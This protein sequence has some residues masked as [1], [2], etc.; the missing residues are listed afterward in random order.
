M[1]SDL[2]TYNSM[3]KRC[4]SVHLFCLLFLLLSM[5]LCA[6]AQSDILSRQ[7]SLPS[8]YSGSTDSLLSII[9]SQ[10]DITISYS[11]KVYANQRVSIVPSTITLGDLLDRIF[12]RFPVEY[13][14]REGRLSKVIVA[15]KKVRRFTLSGYCRDARTGELLIGANV[16]DTLL[17]AG[18]ATNDYGFF[19][20]TLPEGQVGAKASFVGYRTKRFSVNLR[21]DTL[22]YI[23]LEPSLYLGNVDVVATERT[24][25]DYG[26]GTV[27][28]PMEQVKSMPS[29]MGEAD[30]IKALQSTPGVQSG[31]EGFG[32]MSVRGGN[33]DQNIIM[34]DDV[35]LYGP[36]HL[37]GLYSIFN[38]ESVNSAT[39][40]KGGFPARYGGRLSSVLDVKMK[41]GNMKQYNGYANIGLLAS[42]AT[43]EG[44]IVKDKMSFIVSA[45]RTYADIFSTFL[46]RHRDQRYSFFFYDIHAKVNYV[47][48][49]R[50]RVYAS[51]FTGYDNFD[52]GY[53]YREVYSS[54]N[55][56]HV[57]E[58]NDK[59]TVRWGNIVASARWNHLFGSSLFS[60]MTLA[61]S[62]YRFSNTLDNYASEGRLKFTQGYYSG[63]NDY[64]AQA[65]FNWYTPFRGTNDRPGSNVVR[66]GSGVTYHCF[67]PGMFI[68]S[69]SNDSIYSGMTKINAN[70]RRR[71]YRFENHSYVESD[72][73]L[74]RLNVNAGLHLSS[75]MCEGQSTSVRVE[76]RLL[77]GYQINDRMR[78]NMGFSDMTQFMQLLRMVSVASPADMW[79]PVSTQMKT[80]H[81]WQLS[82]EFE[83]MFDKHFRFTGEVY[84]KQYISLQACKS[85]SLLVESIL[86]N[87]W[88]DL[89]TSGKGYSNGLEVFLHRSSGRMSGWVGYSISSARNRFS[90]INDG[91]YFPADYD[92]THSVSVFGCYHFND[93][94]DISATWQYNTGAPTTISDSHYTIKGTDW[95]YSVPVEGERNAYRMPSSHMLNIGVN[96]KRSFTYFQRVLSFGVYNVYGRKNPT[97]TYWKQQEDYKL[98]QFSLVAVPWPYVKYSIKF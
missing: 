93:R 87:D 8:G 50:D 21:S 75:L 23:S 42:D 4:I 55:R 84:H 3:Q 11:N 59:R 71:I 53:N 52:F 26:T 85:A 46:Q 6:L 74:G 47:I 68:Y 39:L 9:D 22:V 31:D 98:K 12:S 56:R 44:P 97:F 78:V 34:L 18:Q 54:K 19:S 37:A 35:P 38:S 49:P 32:G 58:I 81:A 63:I 48:S 28:V 62:R 36:N 86:K 60:N 7:I 66:F 30:V 10:H 90:E 64:S 40:I 29:L 95:S 91:K 76:P 57:T 15:Q 80:P 20:L 96:F 45:R 33:A 5:P 24:I 73:T 79:M 1:I 77:V 72:F 13:L 16:Y 41:N 2:V 17:Y 27:E 65:E 14:V 70:S 94:A 89:Y 51:F 69:A 67:Y 82:T 92:R 88:T 83:V 43:F 25:A 61:Y